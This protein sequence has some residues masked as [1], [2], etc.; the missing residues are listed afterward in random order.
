M[1]ISYGKLIYTWENTHTDLSKNSKSECAADYLSYKY[2]IVC[3]TFSPPPSS[4]HQTRKSVCETICFI[5]KNKKQ[6]PPT[7]TGYYIW[8]KMN[9][10]FLILCLLLSFYCQTEITQITSFKKKI[11]IQ[12]L[13][14]LHN[15]I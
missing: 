7:R 8:A 1:H 2:S 12:F 9:F 6:K 5:C 14:K 4:L 11:L 10:I 3:V 15:L 13:K